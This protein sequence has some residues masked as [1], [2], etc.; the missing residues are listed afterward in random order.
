M[1]KNLLRS[2]ETI[3]KTKQLSIPIK[4]DS[5]GYIDKQC[6]NTD[7]EF[8]FKVNENDWRNI[9]RDEVVWCP[10]CGHSAEP[11][12]WFTI[13]QVEHVKT[14]ALTV[15]QGH[16]NQA[17]RDDA[18]KFNSRKSRNNF[19]SMSMNVSG[20]HSRT[21]IFPAAAT[22]AMQLE[23]Q[24]EKCSSRFAVI[25][26]AYFCPAC[27]HNSVE[28][29][30][31]DSLR[32][33]RAKKDNME[34][35]RAAFDA[36]GKKDD[37]EL[38]CR[39]LI[40]TCLQDGVTAFQKYCEKLYEMNPGAATPPFNAFQ[41]LAQGSDLWH[42]VIGIGYND[43][44]STKQLDALNILFQK[45]H[46]LAHSEGI[47]DDKYIKMSGDKT[48]KVGQ[49]IGVSGFEVDDLVESLTKLATGL[50]A[51]AHYPPALIG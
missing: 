34:L 41:R 14:E 8:L 29:M 21:F 40:E 1:F 27:G 28:R 31:Q 48:Y 5:K 38:T 9:F 17:M 49:H 26:S 2:L 45:R 22:E 51:S 4:T 30:F 11:K 19:I 25:G 6:P 44:L 50:R 18:Q 47:V 15:L 39:S 23:I 12:Q 36:V 24:C 35:V 10:M 33:I 3:E 43:L 42:A 7:C 20:G 13:A 37:G 16:I 46:L 32:K